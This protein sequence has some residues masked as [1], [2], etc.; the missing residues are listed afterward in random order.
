ML[1]S[2]L[3]FPY[4]EFHLLSSLEEP[5]L[6]CTPHTWIEPLFLLILLYDSTLLTVPYTKTTTS[7]LQLQPYREKDKT[8]LHHPPLL[9]CRV[10]RWRAS[11]MNRETRTNSS[12][13]QTALSWAN[14]SNSHFVFCHSLLEDALTIVRIFN[15]Y[16][17]A[18][19]IEITL[20]PSPLLHDGF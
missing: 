5:I 4:A 9:V 13:A 10:R 8:C 6:W 1:Q 16:V 11:R 17:W 7:T 2:P 15:H 12:I 20:G 19:T 3:L 18:N 14:K